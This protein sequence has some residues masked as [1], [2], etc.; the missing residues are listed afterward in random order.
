MTG[1]ILTD[2]ELAAVRR[3][4]RAA[5]LLPAR[6]YQDPAILDWERDHIVRR[7]WVL[8]ARVEDVPEP[9][10][11]RLFDLDGENVIIVRGRD[12]VIRAFYNVCRHRGTAVE[13]RECGKA[14]RFQCVYHAWIYDLDGRLV[15]AKHTEDLED[16]SFEAYGLR[17]IRCETWG[18]F[19]FLC[20][21]DEAV[22]PSLREAMGDWG[23][24]HASMG[25]DMSTLRR[26]ARLTYDVGANWKI[27]AENYSECYHCPPVHKMLNRLTPYDLGEDFLA[28]GPWKGGWMPFAEGCET[29]SMSGKRDGRPLLYARDETEAHRIFYYILWPNL[30]VSVHP[31]YVLVHQA[32]PDGPNRSTVH[33]D[34]YVEADRLD[35]IDV[36]GAVEFWDLT[37]REDY[38]VVEL[39]QQGTRSRSW[40]AGRYSNQEASVHAFD[41]MV[42][43][44][45]ANDGSRT[46]RGWRTETASDRRLVT[47]ILGPAQ[48]AEAA[49]AG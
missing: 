5:S 4:Y 1:A 45:Y 16:F 21:A 18:G 33:C 48:Q 23:D 29:M 15:R 27:V 38:H 24:H 30:I 34:L 3:E 39:Q 35:S 26:A 49:E 10:S 17:E 31:D 46:V 12:D 37:N 20:F 11:F 14:V 41:I 40:T 32:W 19:V 2:A 6:T 8:V 25:R 7:D 9:T 44:R 13:E 42:A 47:K 43:D 22:T 36:S 28:E